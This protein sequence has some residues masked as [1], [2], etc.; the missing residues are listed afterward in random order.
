MTVHVEIGA[1]LLA[2]ATS[3]IEDKRGSEM[4][5]GIFG[6]LRS[7]GRGKGM[8]ADDIRYVPGEV[9]WPGPSDARYRRY[10]RRYRWPH[11]QD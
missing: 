11:P 5:A 1:T 3:S 2:S 7:K 4:L 6:A 8:P 10:G 9:N